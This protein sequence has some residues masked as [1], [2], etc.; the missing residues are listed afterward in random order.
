MTFFADHFEAP[1]MLLHLVL[2]AAV[3]GLWVVARRKRRRLLATWP[4][5]CK[6]LT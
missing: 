4:Y 3:A 6:R 2:V 5:F 1:A